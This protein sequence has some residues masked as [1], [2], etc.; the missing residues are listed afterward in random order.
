MGAFDQIGIDAGGLAM[1][2]AID[3]K[4]LQRSCMLGE[5]RWIVRE[6]LTLYTS[7]DD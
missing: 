5:R 2:A 1:D 6:A 7:P 3:W 4:W